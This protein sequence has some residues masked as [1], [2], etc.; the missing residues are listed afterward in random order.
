MEIEKIMG[1]VESLANKT[2]E[3]ASTRLP[4]VQNEIEQI[5]CS[6]SID[7]QNVEETLNNLLDLCIWNVGKSDFF[8]FL[9]W[10]SPIHPAMAEEYNQLF[11]EFIRQNI[12]E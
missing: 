8:S 3:I 4:E 6:E 9:A 7:F 1:L 11:F 5:K 2:T 10:L 12:E